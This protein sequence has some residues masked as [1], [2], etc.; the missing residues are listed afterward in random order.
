[1]FSL[2]LK[3]AILMI[4]IILIIHFLIKNYLTGQVKVVVR[5]E[6]PLKLVEQQ[7]QQRPLV[8]VQEQ[9]YNDLQKDE[10]DL[11]KFI[12]NNK[13]ALNTDLIQ[14]DNTDNTYNTYNSYNANNANN[15]NTNTNV[16]A[17]LN[18]FNA[19]ST[20]KPMQ[21]SRGAAAA[22]DLGTFSKCDFGSPLL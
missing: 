11:Y 8:V 18:S 5:E 3:N 9:I 6:R 21:L 19:T 4:L 7:Q 10:D 12:F 17:S 16:Q 13:V 1:M 2:A 20:N 14:N 22:V 15:T